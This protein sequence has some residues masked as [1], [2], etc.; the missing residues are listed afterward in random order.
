MN[1]RWESPP[2]RRTCLGCGAKDDKIQLIRLRADV[3]G[4]LIADDS[5]AGRGGY[6]HRAQECWE[7]FTRR[8]NV[9]R[10]FRVDIGKNARQKLVE[11]LKARHGE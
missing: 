1:N 4:E 11:A 8:K 9:Y 3:Q 5:G 2:G 7:K 10:A 6:L